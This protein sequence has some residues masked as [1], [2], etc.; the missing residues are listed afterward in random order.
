[1]TLLTTV[2]H[3]RKTLFT[4]TKRIMIFWRLLLLQ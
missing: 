3:N 2:Q 1:M 4:H